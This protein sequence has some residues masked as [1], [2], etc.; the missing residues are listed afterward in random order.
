MDILMAAKELSPVFYA[1]H[2]EMLSHREGKRQQHTQ[3]V[4]FELKS[5]E[6][7]S[8]KHGCCNS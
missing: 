5:I 4:A 1:T 8:V 7:V 3:L 2:P 6:A